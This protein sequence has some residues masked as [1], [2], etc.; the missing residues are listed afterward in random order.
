[1]SNKSEG[2]AFERELCEILREFHF[3]VHNFAQN[4]DGQPADIIACRDGDTYLIDAKL[5]KND[6]FPLSRIEENQRYAMQYFSDC[7][8]KDGWFALKISDGIYMIPMCYMISF[9]QNG[10]TCLS[11]DMIHRYG[12]EVEKWARII[13]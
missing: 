6:T 1:M 10:A 2:N 5:C 9:E 3:W 4:K 11:Y 12:R 8:N 7:G 13:A